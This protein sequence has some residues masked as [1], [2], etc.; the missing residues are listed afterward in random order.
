MVEK[1]TSKNEQE[2]SEYLEKYAINYKKKRKISKTE[3]NERLESEKTKKLIKIIFVF[4]TI[5]G[6]IL[7]F[8]NKKN[9]ISLNKN[10]IMSKAIITDIIESDN[11]ENRITTYVS[12]YI[13]K[14]E[15]STKKNRKIK[16]T[17]EISE[18]DFDSY[19]NK[20]IKV[21]DTI[22]IIYLPKKPELNKLKRIEIM[23]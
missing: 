5:I 20:E 10:G 22:E 16:S 13:L 2:N 3:K 9:E 14:F 12:S 7:Y 23:K 18:S 4:L 11:F 21:S 17:V 15:F 19:F 1:S 6:L 8:F